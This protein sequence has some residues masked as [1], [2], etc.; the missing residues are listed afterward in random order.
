MICCREH[1]DPGRRPG[2]RW[3]TPVRHGLADFV[4]CGVVRRESDVPRDLLMAIGFLTA[5]SDGGLLYLRWAFWRP[6]LFRGFA[7]RALRG[8]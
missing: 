3:V 1:L 6:S 7:W 2:W 4:I 5:D 8:L